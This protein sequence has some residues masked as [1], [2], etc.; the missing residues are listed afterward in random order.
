MGDDANEF[1]CSVKECTIHS[2]EVEILEG[3]DVILGH[4]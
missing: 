4:L 1:I 2:R 3:F